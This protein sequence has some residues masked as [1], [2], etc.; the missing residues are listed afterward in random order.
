MTESD[1]P[2]IEMPTTE[3]FPGE[4]LLADGWVYLDLPRSTNEVF[5][6]FVSIVGEANVRFMTLARYPNQTVR[7]QCLIS[8]AGMEALK[9]WLE[10]KKAGLQ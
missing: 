4:T 6:E 2:E 8:P 1:L 3:P 9:V 5:E 10:T 7:G